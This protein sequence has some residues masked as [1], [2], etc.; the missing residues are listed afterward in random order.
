MNAPKLIRVQVEFIEMAHKDL[1]RLMMDD[2]SE[3]ADATA[4]RMKVQAS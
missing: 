3:T 4:L 1:T 2:K